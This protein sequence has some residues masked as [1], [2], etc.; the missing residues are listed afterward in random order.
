MKITGL[1][2]TC[3]ACPSQWEALTIHNRSVYIRYRWG[4]LSIW[5]SNFPKQHGLEGKE[6]YRK[7]LGNELDG[8]LSWEEI[9]PIV[10]NLQEEER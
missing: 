2:Q 5:V 10:A 7:Q 4:Y 1:R 6:V 8:C 9:A 3:N